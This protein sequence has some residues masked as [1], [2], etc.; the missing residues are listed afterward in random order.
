MRHG[1][2]AVDVRRWRGHDRAVSTTPAEVIEFWFGPPATTD[3]E[4]MASIRRWFAGGSAVDVEI[5]ERFG[6]AVEAAVAGGLEDWNATA[7]G[8]LALVI[9]LDQ[10]T[11]NVYRDQARMYAG[12]P[13]A[14]AIALESFADG[15]AEKLGFVERVFLS[16]PLL[17]SE[18]LALHERLA[19]IVDALEPE[20]P[21]PYRKMAAMHREQATKFRGVI[22]RF[23]R[24]P[25]R[26]EILGRATGPEEAELLADWH[27]KGPPTGAPV[28]S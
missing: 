21:P 15:T 12:D 13:R 7:D 9:L 4:V 11:R 1:A 3:E 8:R 10:L 26:N 20:A 19:E 23:G 16:M 14:Q 18:D 22:A 24:F 6:A 27:V 28:R 17:H 5:T 25:H 2:S